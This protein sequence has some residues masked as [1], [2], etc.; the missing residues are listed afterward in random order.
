MLQ[1][2]T[3]T[4]TAVKKTDRTSALGCY[5]HTHGLLSKLYAP[6]EASVSMHASPQKRVV[7]KA[8]YKLHCGSRGIVLELRVTIRSSAAA[9]FICGTS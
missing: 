6:R 4:T 3:A 7:R 8:P 9:Q 1:L 5:I 2:L